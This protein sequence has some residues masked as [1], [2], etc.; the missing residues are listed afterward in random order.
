MARSRNNALEFSS[1]GSVIV[2]DSGDE[3]GS[4]GA[5]QVLQDTTLGSTITATNVSG[6]SLASKVL[7]AGTVIYGN[8]TRVTVTS[9]LVALHK[10]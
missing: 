7:G 4:F 6:E 5:I 2:T 3:S 9:G 8:F 1:A 10:V